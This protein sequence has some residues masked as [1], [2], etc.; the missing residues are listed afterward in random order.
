[1]LLLFV[2]Q[3]HYGPLMG[4]LF[5]VSDKKQDELEKTMIRYGI[6]EED[7][8]EQFIRGG[9][10]GG[11][12]INKTSSCVRLVYLPTGEEVRCQRERSLSQNRFL[13][14]RLLI[15]KIV[16]R[17]EG[18]K[19]ERQQKIE[20]IRRQKRKRSKRAKEKMLDN[21]KKHSQKKQ[22]RDIRSFI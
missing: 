19:S 9:G 4:P 1:M 8:E 16:E 17:I 14:R 11:Q 13:A 6:R 15:Q 2:D 20:K 7:F 18:T 22:N 10:A 12:K 21:K 5:P 3:L